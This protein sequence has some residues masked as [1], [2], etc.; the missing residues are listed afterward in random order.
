MEELTYWQTQSQTLL[1]TGVDG[2]LG[3]NLAVALAD[4]FSVVGLY[5]RRP[6]ILPGCVTEPWEWAG[7]NRWDSWIRRE[8]PAWIVHCGPIATGSWD[9]PH[10]C[11]DGEDEARTCVRLARIASE[12]ES[13]LTVISSDA[14]FAGP[15]L[16]HD[17]GAP[18]TSRD[19]FAGAV[20]CVEDA[21]EATSALVVRT[22]VFGWSPAGARPGFAERV[23]QA[24]MRGGPVE[25]DPDRHATP[26]LA[27]SLAEL[28]YSAY[29]RRL[30]GRY[31]IAGAERV[32]AY[33][34]AVELAAAFGLDPPDAPRQTGAV[35]CRLPNDL[36]ETSLNTRRAQRALGRPMP[37]LRDGLNRFAAQGADG[38]HARL[39]Y[40]APPWIE[41]AV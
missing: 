37:M 15:R 1:V 10:P 39:Q 26:I 14:V 35:E 9:L 2:L 19:P 17:E 20:R 6:V 4:R 41:A 28:L 22:H 40:D 36:A 29:R 24:L 3:A 21:L 32:S 16:F 33:R 5:L 25:F 7:P 27:N 11:P 30:Q 38:F 12:T 18:A 23:W 34:F 31:H 8:R 13:R